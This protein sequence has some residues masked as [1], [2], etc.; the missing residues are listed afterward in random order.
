[1]LPD[2][3]LRHRQGFPVSLLLW[4]SCIK[5]PSCRPSP[6]T[7]NSSAVACVRLFTHCLGLTVIQHVPTSRSR[8]LKKR[9]STAL[10]RVCAR[11]LFAFCFCTC[12]ET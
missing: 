1:M 11:S 6:L 9:F 7:K 5:L 4:M 10:R 3:S 12:F 8:A 2:I